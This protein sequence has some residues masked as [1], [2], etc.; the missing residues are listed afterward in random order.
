M[1][2]KDFDKIILLAFSASYTQDEYK[3]ELLAII[4]EIVNLSLRSDKFPKEL[5]KALVKP[6]IKKTSLDLSTYRTIGL[7]PI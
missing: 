5:K 6:V 1:S 7:S 2:V 4:T 3:D